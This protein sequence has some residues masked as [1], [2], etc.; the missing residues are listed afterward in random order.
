[1]TIKYICPY[2]QKPTSAPNCFAGKTG[3]C[4]NCKKEVTV[5]KQNTLPKETKVTQK[6]A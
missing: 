5:P 6:S 1:M 4:T 2:C 3:W